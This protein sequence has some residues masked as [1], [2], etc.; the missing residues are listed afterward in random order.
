M[1]MVR[2]KKEFLVCTRIRAVI[3]IN[4]MIKRKRPACGVFP[5]TRISPYH[6][7]S[8]SDMIGAAVPDGGGWLMVRQRPERG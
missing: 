3:I 5:N 7:S 8:L 2:R 1:I 4:F 6:S